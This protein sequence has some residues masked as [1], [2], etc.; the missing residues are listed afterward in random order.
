MK[1][2][3][4][5]RLVLAPPR[6]VLA[7]EGHIQSKLNRES[8]TEFR[9]RIRSEGERDHRENVGSS[10]ELLGNSRERAELLLVINL[11]TFSCL[12]IYL[13]PDNWKTGDR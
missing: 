5:L 6:L 13:S 9:A 4:F 10:L 2:Y 12:C 8:S 1:L 11:F 3:Y 7:R